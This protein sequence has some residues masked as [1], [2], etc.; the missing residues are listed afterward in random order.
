MKKCLNFCLVILVLFTAASYS[1]SAQT[2]DAAADKAKREVQRRGQGSKVVVTTKDGTKFKGRISQILDDS[3]DVSD[4]STG[5]NT[6]PYRDVAKIRKPG[7]S[8]TQIALIAVGASVV[9]LALIV[10]A[11]NDFSGD[12]CP[13]GC[14]PR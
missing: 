5:P 1:V 3:F 12:I 6:I 9:V 4:A 7:L 2:N 11:N 10:T 14:G 13:L 8:K